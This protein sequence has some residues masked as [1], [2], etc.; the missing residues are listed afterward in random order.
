MLRAI[1]EIA[2]ATS[3]WSVVENPSETAISRPLW[4]AVTMS[5]SRSMSTL[6]SLDT[7]GVPPTLRA[8]ER[9]PFLQIECRRDVRQREPELDHRERD[10]GLYA[11][12]HGDR[13]AQARGDRDPSDHSAR[14]RVEHVQGGYVDD[15]AARSFR[16]DS[17]RELVAQ[18]HEIVVGERRLDAR[19]ER[20]TLFQ[21]RNRHRDPSLHRGEVVHASDA[22]AEEALGIL[23]AALE[24][25]DGVEPRKLDAEGDQ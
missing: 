13:P 19:D 2:V 9:E 18:L 14:K 12:D 24:I 11:D 17:G 8:Q 6:V 3:V 23:D 25:S 16:A 20:V 22:I 7:G 1:S 4:R 21:N 5:G 15:H 10:V